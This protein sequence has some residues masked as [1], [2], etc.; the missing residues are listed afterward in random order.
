MTHRVVLVGMPASGKTTVGRILARRLG[1]PFVD[2]DDLVAR[3]L[4]VSVP[5]FIDARGERAFRDEESQAVKEANAVPGAVIATGG[6][7][8]LDPVNRW[9]LWENSTVA[10]LDV[11]PDR[12]VRRLAADPVARPTF[13]PYRR[14]TMARTL[15][16]RTFAYRSADLR[17]EASA[18]PA[19]VA[20]ELAELAGPR[21]SGKRLFDADI[22]RNH[23][24]GPDTTR[25]VMGVDHLSAAGLQGFFVIDR[26]LMKVAP[27]VMAAL[28]PGTV[29]AVAS[30]ERA[31]RMRSVER[32]LEEMSRAGVERGTPVIAVGG[33][34]I[35]DLVGTA[36]ALFARGMP[37]IHVPITWLAQADSAIG[38]KVA[39]DL[40]R[41]KNAAGAFW[42]PV[43]IFSE[44]AALRTLPLASRRDGMAECIKTGM[45][46]DPVLWRLIED[47]G[48]AALR[49]D[50]ASRYAIIERSARLKL[51]ICGR[52]PF[53]TGERRTLN[54]GHTI[55][56][57][58]EIESGYRLKHGAAVALGMRAVA[59][60]SAG[61]GADPDLAKR[62]DE[63]LGSLGYR[64]HQV[65]DEAIV[66]T[67]MLRD[68]KREAGR[69]RWILPMEIGRMVEVDDVSE[70][71]V[72][73]ALAAIRAR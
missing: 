16:D 8:V 34:T 55:G 49:R 27:Q 45:I 6:G 46:G 36:A 7:T 71:E 64:L 47:R 3:R 15:A 52:D 28:S 31:K 44:L 51:A 10:W 42:P 33:G 38:G 5:D 9:S 67:A 43:A 14:E 25:L 56:H 60:I 1:R 30:G 63:L 58:L 61:R 12:L 54:L 17:V 13:Q 2:I 19:A 66:R 72:S 21:Q 39:V 35:G 73:A 18:S 24:V 68:K 57:A 59:A 40:G 53:E 69:Q 41:A 65:F 4:G 22:P 20:R 37:L 50:E 48:S 32:V 26:R 62:L 11:P 29:L 23:P 70:R